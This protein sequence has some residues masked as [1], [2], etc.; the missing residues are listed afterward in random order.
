[1]LA[2]LA[3][4]LADRLGC[5][6]GP[7]IGGL[8]APIRVPPVPDALAVPELLGLAHEALVSRSERRSRGAHYTPADVADG[9]VSLALPD[10]DEPPTVCDPAV[11]GGV[12]LLAAG[13]ALEGW[14]VPRHRI[15]R[16]LLFGADVDALA[17]AV[18]AASLVLWSA[19]DGCPT[20]PGDHLCTGDALELDA[21]QVWG[22]GRFDLVVGNPPFSSPL[23]AQGRGPGGTAAARRRLLAEIGPYTDQAALFLLV[24][25]RLARPGGR[26]SLLQPESFLAARDAAPIRQRLLERGSLTGIWVADS[27]LFAAGVRVVAP[28]IEVG[29][30]S[31]E[32]VQRWVGAGFTPAPPAPPVRAGA[33]WSALVADLRGVPAPDLLTAAPLGE[34]CDVGAGFRDEYY[35]LRDAVREAPAGHLPGPPLVTAGLVDPATCHWGHRPVRFDR[36]AW[37]RPWVD[38]GRLSPRI[39]RWVDGRLVPKVVVAPQTS[40]IEA[41]VDESG[42]WVPCTPLVTLRTTPDLLWPVAAVLLAP[43]VSALAHRLGAGT[44]LGR[45]VVRLNVRQVAALPQPVDDEAWRRGAAAVARAS[46]ATDEAGWRRQLLLAARAMTVAYGLDAHHEVVEWREERLPNWR[47]SPAPVAPSSLPSGT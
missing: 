4:R 34:L 25:L 10:G 15:V 3:A 2:G 23:D 11:G 39:R 40:V 8:P 32:P 19:E 16:E 6:A 38:L 21:D 12:F 31:E 24:A 47:R 26:I 45:D 36:R 37:Q 17:V 28:M 42:S 27:A 22:R 29:N 46:E 14:G 1:M 35:G 9:L 44:G 13:R 18:A 33:T 20:S 43:P 5:P 7:V 41:A 30:S